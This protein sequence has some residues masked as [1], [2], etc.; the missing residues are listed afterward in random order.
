MTRLTGFDVSWS[1]YLLL[2]QWTSTIYGCQRSFVML[3]NTRG[4]FNAGGGNLILRDK[5]SGVV[6]DRWSPNTC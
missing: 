5:M 4:M 3:E 1:P 2:L 6:Y